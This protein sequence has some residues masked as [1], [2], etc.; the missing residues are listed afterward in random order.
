MRENQRIIFTIVL[1]QFA[2]DVSVDVRR[3]NRFYR[4]G[5]KFS[6]H[7]GERGKRDPEENR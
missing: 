6:L 1:I 3:Y 2:L 7:K 4:T 5:R